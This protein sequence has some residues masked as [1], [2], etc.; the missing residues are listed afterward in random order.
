M[1]TEADRAVAD[2]QLVPVGA[3]GRTVLVVGIDFSDLSPHLLQTSRELV[4]SSTSAEIHL[5]HVM[6]VESLPP[7]FVD[8]LPRATRSIS[9]EVQRA[10][11]ALDALAAEVLQ[12]AHV[13]VFTHVLA[14]RPQEEIPRLASE[15]GADV[16]VVEAH[17]RTGLRRVLHHSLS[18][19]LARNAPCS[20][21]TVRPKASLRGP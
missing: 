3:G 19:D 1:A 14:G 13:V 10:R 7:E 16:I 21:L 4:R 6:A 2:E 11:E 18:A 9:P 20:V 17:G 12:P 5:V 8:A 15:V